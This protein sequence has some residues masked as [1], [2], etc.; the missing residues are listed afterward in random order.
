MTI[1]RRYFLRK[2]IS[3]DGKAIFITGC[4]SGFGHEIAKRMDNLGYYVFAACLNIQGDGAKKLI[5]LCS[6]RLQVLHL[7]VTSDKSVQAAKEYVVKHLGNNVLWAVLNNAGVSQ[8]GEIDWTPLEEFQRV[9][10]I[11][12]AGTLKVT[13]AFLPLLKKSTGRLINNTSTCGEFICPGFVGYCMSKSAAI[14][15]S[16]GLRIE[17]MKWGVKV[18]SIQPFLYKTPLTNE[19][20]VI[21]LTEKT[22]LKSDPQTRED[23]GRPH[24]RGT[25]L[26]VHARIPPRQT[27]YQ[28]VEIPPESVGRALFA[29]SVGARVQTGNTHDWEEVSLNARRFPPYE[30]KKEIKSELH[31]D[32]ISPDFTAAYV[33]AS[34]FLKKEARIIPLFSCAQCCKT[35]SSK[36]MLEKHQKTHQKDKVK[37]RHTCSMCPY[38][39]NTITH[40]KRHFLIHSGE[41]PFSCVICGKAFT[42]KWNMEQHIRTH[43][44]EKPYACG[45]CWVRFADRSDCSRHQSVHYDVRPYACEQCG[46]TFK[47]IKSLR[48]HENTHLSKMST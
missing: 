22:W 27:R 31:L 17:L 43:T 34:D 14:A 1:T 4:D 29:L 7:D 39:T 33:K 41:R 10:E 36:S 42:T 9:Y 15:L 26:H 16:V 6:P 21:E 8:A 23:Y 38:S 13:K 2:K 45:I 30:Y 24:F 25:P 35:F 47:H 32:F 20:T 5:N 19:D 18:I 48:R 44:G 46:L 12:A 28:A 11:N 37:L 40:L 3:S